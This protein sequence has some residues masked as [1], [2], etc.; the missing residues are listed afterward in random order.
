MRE[1]DAKEI[2]S[3]ISRLCQEASFFL[4]ED[5]QNAL[6]R[7]WGEEESPTGRRILKK[8]LENASIASDEKIPLCQDTGAV[9]LF[10][11]VGQEVH[12]TGGDLYT[13]VNEG[14][15]QGYEKG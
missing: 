9:V 14:V 7:A 5:V 8:L 11:E 3:T 15:R 2:A 6:K 1:I 13:A 12:I 4:P 10:L